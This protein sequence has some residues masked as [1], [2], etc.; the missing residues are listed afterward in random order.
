[1]RTKHIILNYHQRCQRLRKNSISIVWINQLKKI[2]LL[3]VIIIL[4]PSL[5]ESDRRA[6]KLPAK[7]RFILNKTGLNKLKIN[8]QQDNNRFRWC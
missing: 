2:K 3:V 1:M 7:F 4:M 6:F 8:I 5:L